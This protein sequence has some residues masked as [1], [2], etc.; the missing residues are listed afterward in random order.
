MVKS[1]LQKPIARTRRAWQTLELRTTAAL[2]AALV[3]FP[4]VGLLTVP[5]PRAQGLERLLSQVSLIQ[6]FPSQGRLGAPPLWQQRLG[7]SLAGVVWNRQ[8]LWW[9]FWAE[10][11]DGGAYLAFPWASLPEQSRTTLPPNSFRVDDLL[12][13]APDPL[14]QRFMRDE[15]QLKQRQS[16]GLLQR[17][18]QRLE[19]D[20]SLYWSPA[21]L[22]ELVGPLAPLLQHVQQ[23]CLSLGVRGD[24]LL[25]SGEASASQG[26]LGSPQSTD[27]QPPL[28]TL[29]PR[30]L[31][32]FRA[33]ELGPLLEGL[34]SR[35]LIREPLAARYGIAQPQLAM[36]RQ[37]PVLLRLNRLE[38]G[39]F[40][41][42]LELR[43]LVGSHHRQWAALLQGLRPALMNQGLLDSGPTVQNPAGALQSSSFPTAQ[44]SREDGQVVGGW[45]WFREPG[46]DP[47]LLLFLGP[48]PGQPKDLG[49]QEDWLPGGKGVMRLRMRPKE[50]AG[51]GLLPGS[52]PKPVQTASHLAIDVAI[53]RRDPLSQL[54]GSLQ[55]DRPR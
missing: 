25:L 39:P 37:T 54:M 4:T 20:Q 3:L 5:R 44:W 28:P 40:Q 7:P 35:Q 16:Q 51:L 10:H 1:L 27:F 8:H 31:L 13:I 50:L 41:A 12:V 24:D 21:G 18:R 43:L 45:R 29:G 17:C 30:V 15:L 19:Q 32:E 42:N 22:G 52:L 26:Y 33:P 14:S 23:G 55:W 47:E 53:N 48:E 11:G 49:G 38:K 46:G 2:I 6:S 9:Q 34:L 36:I